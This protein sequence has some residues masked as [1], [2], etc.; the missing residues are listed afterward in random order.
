MRLDCPL[1]VIRDSA[2]QGHRAVDLLGG[3]DP[4]EFVRK[5]ERPERPDLVRSVD[6]AGM[7]PERS[8]ENDRGERRDPA[9]QHRRELLAPELS[10]PAIERHE[11]YALVQRLE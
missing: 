7:V 5:R 3:D 2:N 9:P 6:Q 11:P 1:F 4:R 8:T 10:S